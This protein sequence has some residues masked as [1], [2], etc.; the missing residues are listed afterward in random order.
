LTG[1]GDEKKPDEKDD[2]D[3]EDDDDD[4]DRLAPINIFEQPLELKPR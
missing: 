4:D 3:M 1:T 2:Q